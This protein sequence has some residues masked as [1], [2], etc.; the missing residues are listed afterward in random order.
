MTE[1]GCHPGRPQLVMTQYRRHI[2]S[3]KKRYGSARSL[4]HYRRFIES[5][6]WAKRQVLAK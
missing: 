1:R 3:A 4:I 5:Y 2:L 6:L